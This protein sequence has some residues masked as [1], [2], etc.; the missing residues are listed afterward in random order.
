M[1]KTHKI[2]PEDAEKI[3]N[4]MKSEFGFNVS[5][6]KVRELS[7]IV[8]GMEVKTTEQ[9]DPEEDIMRLI[10]EGRIEFNQEK[11]V[12]KFNLI[13][14]ARILKANNLVVLKLVY[15]LAGCRKDWEYRL[16]N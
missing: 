8:N 16:Q 12:L 1:K 7:M 9:I 2:S 6:A 3:F 4:Q 15:L 11:K 5:E 13:N 10:C 14:P